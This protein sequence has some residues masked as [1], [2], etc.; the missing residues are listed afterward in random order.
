MKRRTAFIFSLV[1]VMTVG[2]FFVTSG[3]AS[4]NQRVKVPYVLQDTGW[5]TGVVIT[6]FDTDDVHLYAEFIQQDGTYSTTTHRVDL[7]TFGRYEMKVFSLAEL[8]NY[9]RDPD[10]ALPDTTFH[11]W[12]QHWE[13]EEQFGV[14]VFIVSMNAAFPGY[15]FQQFISETW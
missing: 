14:A 8:W 7:G 13:D 1:V 5:A 2:L 10:T 3:T 11:L 15:G 6:N 9:S 12:V 4:A